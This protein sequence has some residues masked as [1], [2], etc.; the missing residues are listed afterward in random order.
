MPILIRSPLWGSDIVL[1]LYADVGGNWS[2]GDYWRGGWHMSR[3]TEGYHWS[4]TPR[5]LIPTA[6]TG[7]RSPLRLT[8]VCKDASGA[9]LAGVTCVA[10]RSTDNVANSVYKYQQEGSIGISDAGGN[11][12]IMVPTA[13][14]YFVVSYKAGA[15]DVAG[16]TVNT[17]VGV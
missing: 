9:P 10:F 1:G 5:F 8:G 6:W 11:Y 12:E 16:T 3:M 14:T 4:D 15:P 2:F 7:H 17:L 13:D